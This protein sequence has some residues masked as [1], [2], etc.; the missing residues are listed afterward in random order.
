[1]EGK[2]LYETPIEV[3]YTRSI[4][5]PLWGGKLSGKTGKTTVGFLSVFDQNTPDMD[6]PGGEPPDVGL[7][8]PRG[9]VNVLRMRRDL[10]SESSIGFILTDKEMGYEGE[11]LTQNY[12]RV[13]GVDGL[14]KFARFYRFT[15][16]ALGS[17]TKLGETK[18]GFAPALTMGL[19]R[20]SRHLQLSADWTSIHPDFE[21]SA[22]FLRRK[23]VHA[24]S[25][26]AAYSFLPQN[27][28]LISVTPSL[29]YRRIY[30]FNR[31]LTDTETD[32]SLMV[33]GWGQSFLWMSYQ[34]S[35]EKYEG[36]DFKAKEWRIHLSA[37]PLSWLSG[38]V[39][40]SFGDAIY[41]SDEPFLGYM[42]G[43]SATVTLK[44]LASLRFYTSYTN[45]DFRTERGGERV[46]R[47]NILSE[48][49]SYQLS[50]PLSVR[51]IADWNDYY[52]KLFVSFLLSYQ[53]N[54]G[55]VFYFGADS[56]RERDE[57]GIFQPTGQYVFLK[58]SYW[59]RT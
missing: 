40:R 58:F 27:P 53:L 14:F 45:N 9:L 48:R 43:W 13:A 42:T 18:T 26:R 37:E 44:P 12:N 10:F 15:F 23:D 46:Y 47:V 30:D 16:Q 22:G 57:A 17:Q 29:S 41:Y 55:T 5:D 7:V 56:G 39:S 54:Q 24:L 31:T 32:F 19:S 1:L 49:V 11:S 21:A 8:P 36:V 3:L 6:I 59:W 34:D 38:R 33:S 28:Y 52:Q 50:K 4:L 51:L 35:F 2:D 25:A 20:Q